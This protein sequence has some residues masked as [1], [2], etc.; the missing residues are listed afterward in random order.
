MALPMMQTCFFAIDDELMFKLKDN[1]TDS[2]YFFDRSPSEDWR[3]RKQ[4]SERARHDE[5]W[6]REGFLW[7][8]FSWKKDGGWWLRRKRTRKYEEEK[9]KEKE[10]GARVRS[11]DQG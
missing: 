10:K 8:G 7:W 2:T 3:R 9:E 11:N 6:D 4:L 1:L 5:D